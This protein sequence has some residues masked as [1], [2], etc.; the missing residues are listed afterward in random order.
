MLVAHM[1]NEIRAVLTDPG[2]PAHVALGRAPAPVC[3]TDQALVRVRAVS[4]NRGELFRASF[5]P[6]GYP[7]GW[8]VGG[9]VEKQAADGSG[10]A[11]GTRVVGFSPASNGWAELVPMNTSYLAPIPDGVSDQDAAAL[12]VAALTALYTLER[13]RRLLGQRV[14]VTGA[15]GGVGMFA[16]QLARLMGAVVVAQ[17]RRSEYVDI[18]RKTGA[19]EIVVDETGEV[20][21]AGEPFHL[22]LD[23][24][25]GP[26]LGHVLT[27]LQTGS[28]AVLYGVTGSATVEV[29]LAPFLF[30]GDGAL[31]GFTLYHEAHLEAPSRGLARLLS[32]VQARK[33][34]TFVTH[35]ASWTEV[36][37]VAADF[38]ARKHPGKVVLLVD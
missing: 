29:G 30:S 1:N 23:G 35:T 34:D 18:V 22:I 8:D 32:L 17:V 4:L 31:Q 19:D 13:V 10:P 12:P 26:M 11:Q 3:N 9:V 5:T 33:L 6:A 15:S 16:C 38:M 37:D 24:V 27:K 36:R 21:A 7:I 2:A 20:L 25:G 14:L 28:T